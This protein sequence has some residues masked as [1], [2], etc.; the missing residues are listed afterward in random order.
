MSNK[1]RLDVVVDMAVEGNEKIQKASKSLSQLDSQRLK[2]IEGAAKMQ[3]VWLGVTSALGTVRAAVD[4]VKK[5]WDFAKEGRQALNMQNTYHALATSMNAD[6]DLMLSSMQ[7]AT[8]GMVDNLTLMENASRFMSMG[9]ATSEFEAAK[10]ARTAVVLGGALGKGPSEAMEEFALLLANQS[11][12]RLDTFGISAGRVRTRINELMAATV[13]L[14]R[15]DAFLMAVNEEAAI[16]MERLGDAIPVDEFAQFE[17][18]ITNIKTEMQMAAAEGLGPLVSKA[19]D[20]ILSQRE[21]SAA[22]QDGTLTLDQYDKVMK[23]TSILDG[24]AGEAYEEL[25]RIIAENKAEQQ[26]NHEALVKSGELAGEADRKFFGMAE[27]IDAATQSLYDLAEANATVFADTLETNEV[28]RNLNELMFDQ[29]VKAGV[30]AEGLR[31]LAEASGIASTEQAELAYQNAVVAGKVEALVQKFYDGEISADEMAAAVNRLQGELLGVQGEYNAHVKITVSGL[32]Q[33]ERAKKMF[34]GDFDTGAGGRGPSTQYRPPTYG[35]NDRET[36]GR[37]GGTA[38][39]GPTS[40]GAPTWVGERGR[41][42]FIPDVPGRIIPQDRIT[43]MGGITVNLTGDAGM[44]PELTGKRI[45]GAIAA[46]LGDM[47]RG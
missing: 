41:E 20:F 47:M 45:A 5:G 6:A 22:L 2:V 34:G 23:G 29:A 39:G 33:L 19:T 7:N 31:A 32:G 38:Y 16:S 12:P 26:R 17:T 15:E 28:N 30:S 46:Q 37:I 42:L 14:T 27:G 35:P 8:N 11:I 1:E 43:N 24:S 9:L 44:A 40:P 4:T 36:T 3:A 10:L 18:N 25:S 13:G 21:I